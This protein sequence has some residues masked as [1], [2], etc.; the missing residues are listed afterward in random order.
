M[1]VIYGI[2]TNSCVT[3][4]EAIRQ[5]I[6]ETYTASLLSSERVVADTIKTK[7]G[8]ETTGSFWK[9]SS[10]FQITIKESVRREEEGENAN[11]K[12]V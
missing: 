12:I 4:D 11:K 9:Y 6:K 8:E 2:S 7:F 3:R 5:V 10:T 1:L